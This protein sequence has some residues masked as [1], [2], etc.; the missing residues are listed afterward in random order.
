M[1]V[2]LISY[3][4]MG[5]IWGFAVQ[6]I[7]N[8][9]GYDENWFWW[10][11]FFG[12]VAVLVALSK[13]ERTYQSTSQ[14]NSYTY[15]P[16]ISLSSDKSQDEHISKNTVDASKAGTQ[17]LREEKEGSHYIPIISYNHG[18]GIRLD[19]LSCEP[20]EGGYGFAIA[21]FKDTERDVESIMADIIL[22]TTFGD[23]YEVKNVGF[24]SFA[25]NK[26]YRIISGI[27]VRA[28][29]Q[30]QF[31]LVKE[32]DIIIKKYIENGQVIEVSADNQILCPYD[33]YPGKDKEI[34]VAALLS[35]LE[36]LKSAKEVYDC[37]VYYSGIHNRILDP[38][39]ISRLE[40][41]RTLERMYGS[42]KREAIKAVKEYF[43]G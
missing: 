7:I 12:I 1:I 31:I 14:E 27:T 24:T 33:E 9:K 40:K 2:A 10:G 19:W 37:V 18:A 15:T 25:F 36:T 32:A 20:C 13:P 29:P 26:S 41:M 30:E 38:E 11:F 6:A 21:L 4:I 22:K 3:C 8:N 39:F 17:K 35:E 43:V 42:M 16:S 28:I 5:V 23:S 34:D